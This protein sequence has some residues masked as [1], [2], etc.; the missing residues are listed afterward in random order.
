MDQNN[1]RMISNGLMTLF[2]EMNSY[3]YGSELDRPTFKFSTNMS[4]KK[5]RCEK[6]QENG[7]ITY[8]YIV[9]FVQLK[10]ER[11]IY[12]LLKNM[13]DQYFESHSIPYRKGNYFYKAYGEFSNTHGLICGSKSHAPTR[14]KEEI[15]QYIENKGLQYDFT[16]LLPV[17]KKGAMKYVCPV[18]GAAAFVYGETP[19]ICGR[20]ATY[21]LGCR[22]YYYRIS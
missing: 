11:V 6:K 18:C 12:C 3:L 13:C 22:D 7:K 16:S 21:M 14:A 15:V 8:I 10:R 19:L 5:W 1:L 4:L 17:R 9:S 20:C 2:D